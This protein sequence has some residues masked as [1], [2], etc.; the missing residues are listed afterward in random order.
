MA[1]FLVVWLDEANDELDELLDFVA[2]RSPQAALGIAEEISFQVGQLALF[3]HLGHRGRVA[4]TYELVVSH[5]PCVV[6]YRVAGG[7]V[8]ILHMFHSRRDW[9][10][11]PR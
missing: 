8:Q 7:E 6:V 4:G 5:T 2:E 3:P 11:A 10:A 9:P 1:E